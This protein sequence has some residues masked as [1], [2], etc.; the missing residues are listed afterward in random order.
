MVENL[1]EKKIF[2]SKKN[3]GHTRFLSIIMVAVLVFCVFA[4]M[5][6]VDNVGSNSSAE[7]EVEK[8]T[9]DGFLKGVSCG[10][11]VPDIQQLKELGANSV[12]PSIV[13][14]DV[15]PEIIN[16]NLTVAYVD[17]HPEVISDYP[18]D[19]SKADNIVDTLVT[20]EIEPVIVVGLGYTNALSTIDGEKATPDLLGK[21]KYLGCI[22]RHSRAVVRRYKDKVDYWQIEN[23]LNEAKLT[24]LFGWRDGVAWGDDAFLTEL[25]VTLNKAVKI[26]DPTGK[27]TMNFHTDVHENIHDELTSFAGKNN[28]TEWLLL[29]D[30]YLDIIGIDCY[31]NYY[32]SDPVYGSDVGDRIKIVR[33]IVPDKPVIVLETSYP[34]PEPDIALPDPVNFTEEK[35]EQYIR[36]AIGSAMEHGALGYFHFT[37]Q[38]K[39]VKGPPGGYTTEDL[40]ALATLGP[41]FRNGD[42]ETLQAFLFQ[43]LDYVQNRLPEVLQAVEDGWGIIR[44]DGTPRP[45]F[46]VLKEAFSSFR[47]KPP[48]L[49]TNIPPNITVNEDIENFELLNCSEY[50]SDEYSY[51]RPS[52]YALEYLSNTNN[53]SLSIQG[54]HLNVSSVED[55]WTGTISVALN[56]TNL[57]DLTTSSNLFNITVV[58]VDDPP[59]WKK[60]IA[61][62]NLREDHQSEPLNLSCYI[63]D[64][65]SDPFDFSSSVNNSNVESNIKE[66][67]LKFTPGENY[68][69][70]ARVSITVFQLSN[71]SLNSTTSFEI[72]V[73]PE[74]DL[75]ITRLELPLNGSNNEYEIITLNWTGA[76]PD[77]P[78]GNIKYHVYVSTELDQV[79]RHNQSILFSTENTSIRLYLDNG[80]YY[81]TVIG[82][83][84][85]GNGS[86]DQGYFSFNI[87]KPM[88]AAKVILISPINGSMIYNNKINLT[89]ELVNSSGKEPI[90]EV[91]FG[92]SK[93]NLSINGTTANKWYHLDNLLNDTTYYWKVVPVLGNL[94][95]FC[96]NGIWHFTVSR[97]IIHD[98]LVKPKV[99]ELIIEQGDTATF[100]FT[101][102]NKGNVLT[103]VNFSVR[104]NLSQ[105]VNMPPG[106]G[107]PM[108]GSDD[109]FITINGTTTIDIGNYEIIINV[110]HPGRNQTFIVALEIVPRE[111]AQE[112]VD[113]EDDFIVS[114]TVIGIIIG[115]VIILLTILILVFVILPKRKKGSK[116]ECAAASE[117]DK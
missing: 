30:P 99:I 37:L 83:D 68:Y 112:V 95:G 100:N 11:Y 26:E 28:W 6:S 92:M 17:S 18:V 69:G 89:W 105:Y 45:A 20:N 34:A 9:I 27:T 38:E 33:E 81:W 104:G 108:G 53:I 90:F 31:P 10:G 21:E 113:M 70:T 23:E 50:F 19:W 25:I 29:W 13:W 94:E 65:E 41:A 103:T 78:F 114:G 32:I 115:G 44:D 96:T 7:I 71:H 59:M 109:I 4:G 52:T 116:I 102:I 60:P 93:Q 79:L 2:E 48:V 22:Y 49:K 58:A 1:T 8:N 36:D 64:A 107:L 42:T 88:L 101:I 111:A 110:E 15:E 16:S 84:G 55:N 14:R 66:G 63:E 62:I 106:I 54:P 61:D 91:Y 12:R 51:I 74:N 82:Y 35:Q 39:G 77:G 24:M 3:T 5:I 40:D 87:S 46:Y 80:A 73:V 117:K 72:S 43:N 57:F 67:I 56:C 47:L 76:D 75:P 86:C 98:V 97:P 85:M